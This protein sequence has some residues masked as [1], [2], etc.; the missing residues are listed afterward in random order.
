MDKYD[1][2][3]R[4]ERISAGKNTVQDVIVI[5]GGIYAQAGQTILP[6]ELATMAN[7]LFRDIQAR[8]SSLT[9]QEVRVAFENGVRGDYG[10]FYGLSIVTFNNWLK[11]YKQSEERYK[12]VKSLN[13][14]KN[15]LPAPGEAYNN[16]KMKEMCLRYFDSYKKTGNPGF[17]CVTVYQFLQKEKVINQSKEYKLSVME[18]VRN[19]KK[20]KGALKFPDEILENR[21]KCEAVEICLK[22]FFQELIEMD[23]ELKD[24]ML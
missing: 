10:T 12:A 17:A 24:V 18:K 11:A 6:N 22:A 15:A 7:A 23:M 8:Y 19:S 1:L 3:I 13:R 20:G 21:I 9:M 5:I 4:Q 14:A 2:A 16:Q